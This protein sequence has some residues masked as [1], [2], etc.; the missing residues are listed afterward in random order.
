MYRSSAPELI[1]PTGAYDLSNCVID[2]LGQVYMRGGSVYRSTGAFG[3]SLRWLWDGILANGGH[4]TLLASPTAFGKLEASGAVTSL[5][6]GGLTNP[7]RP[8]VFQG[9]LYFPGGKTYDGSVWGVAPLVANFYTV[10]ANRLIAASGRKI[11]FSQ[12]PKKP[13]D[14]PTF[15]ETDYHEL[16]EGVEIIGLEAGREQCVIFTTGGVWVIGNMALNLTDAAGNVQ[17]RLDHYSGELILWSDAGIAAWEGSLIV[18]A[19]D[20]VWLVKRGVTSEQIGSFQRISDPIRDLYQQYIRMGFTLGVGCVFNNH[21]LLPIVGAGIVQ[22]LLVCRLDVPTQRGAVAGAWS[23]FR[24]FGAGC[25]ALAARLSPSASTREPELLG[26]TYDASARVL[27]CSYFNPSVLTA[28]DADGSVPEWALE[29][30]SFAT[31]NLVPNL[32]SRLRVRYQMLKE[33]S[34]A[35]PTINAEI[36]GASHVSGGII[37]GLFVWGVGKWGFGA[38][39]GSYEPLNGEAPEDPEGAHPFVWNVIKKRRFIRFRLTCKAA[40]GQL[41]LKAIEIFIRQQGRV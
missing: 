19:I 12:I 13:G 26:A 36:A 16:P 11:N 10:V 24:G 28:K 31:G 40:T 2:L 18:P 27:T 41:V 30:R 7:V 22:D 14:A 34:G 4:Q 21:Y 5:G 6:E 9:K 15:A 17:Q 37:W 3:T 20:A 38:A 8:A 29:T 35:A 33:E 25:S 23:H 1:P 39:S 32:V